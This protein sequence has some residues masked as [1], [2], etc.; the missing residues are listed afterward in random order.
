M[1]WQSAR[2]GRPDHAQPIHA[3]ELSRFIGAYEG[4]NLCCLCGVN[5]PSHLQI[6]FIRGHIFLTP[7]ELNRLESSYGCFT[8]IG[9]RLSPFATSWRSASSPTARPALGQLRQSFFRHEPPALPCAGPKEKSFVR[10]L[11][12]AFF[13][14]FG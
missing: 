10:L 12:K 2:P 4:L 14:Q 13:S 11:P 8:V 5:R 1:G 9:L 7:S 3:Q 6:L